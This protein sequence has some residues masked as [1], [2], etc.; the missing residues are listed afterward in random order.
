MKK[1]KIKNSA[2]FF[3][4]LSA[5]TLFSCSKKNA[6]LPVSQSFNFTESPV[7]ESEEVGLTN[8]SIS[9]DVDLDI[10]KM[11]ATMVYAEIFNMIIEPERYVGKTIRIKGQFYVYEKEDQEPYVNGSS[12]VYACVIQDATACCAQGLEFRLEKEMNYPEDFPELYSIVTVVGT[13][14]SEEINGIE[15]TGLKNARFE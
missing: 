15:Y 14:F 3:L 8:E 9:S 13:Y 1:M 4:F 11:S 5:V 10:S 2:F 12:R 7:T 6:V